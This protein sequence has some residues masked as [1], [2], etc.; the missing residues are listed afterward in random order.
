MIATAWQIQL[1]T[2]HTLAFSVNNLSSSA[3]AA[4]HPLAAESAASSLRL[5]STT[6]S[7]ASSHFCDL[8]LEDEAAEY[9]DFPPS[10]ACQRNHDI[11]D[12]PP[13]LSCG[14]TNVWVENGAASIHIPDGTNR[15]NDDYKQQLALPPAKNVSA[16]RST[17]S[18]LSVILLDQGPFTV[19][20]R[21][22]ALCF[23]LNLVGLI[24]AVTGYFPYARE[25]AALFS[26][27][28]IL[29]SVLC[30]SEA[31]FDAFSGSQ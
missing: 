29:A 13:V 28:N 24:A 18:R 8:D 5:F 30:R 9:Q 3:K 25:K 1:L 17:E 20:K 31:F 11:E 7:R 27:G 4:R 10:S 22:F 16:A 12:P 2:L 15:C 14:S 21:L 23:A 6:H 26:I 19:Y